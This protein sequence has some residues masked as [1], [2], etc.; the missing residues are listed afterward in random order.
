MK[1]PT[2]LATAVASLAIG[3]P[4]AAQEADSLQ[5][6]LNKK[7]NESW[8]SHGGWVTD[9]DDAKAQAAKENKVIFAYFTRSYSP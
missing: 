6:K 1:I 9:L 7:L 5:V 8:V 3:L 2:L 4:T